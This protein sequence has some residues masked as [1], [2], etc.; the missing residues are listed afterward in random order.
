MQIIL[1]K[2]KIIL[3]FKIIIFL[4]VQLQDVDPRVVQMYKGVKQVLTTYR[5]G[6]LPK[7]FKLIPKLRNWEQILY[8]TGWLNVDCINYSFY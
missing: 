7:A 4:G 5:S 2:F 1:I 3:N 8:I 6:K